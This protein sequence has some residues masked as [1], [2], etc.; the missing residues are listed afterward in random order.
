MDSD[1]YPDKCVWIN[2]SN[3]NNP[4]RKRVQD[5]HL[6]L[7]HLMEFPA[8]E[9][10]LDEEGETGQDERTVKPYVAAPPLGLNDAYFIVRATFVFAD[11][12]MHQGYMKPKIEDSH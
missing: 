11:G 3:K 1:S 7:G 10:A 6:T 5:D 8:W 2:I 4:M 12:S 9:Y